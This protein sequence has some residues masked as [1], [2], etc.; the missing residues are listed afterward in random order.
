M[1]LVWAQGLARQRERVAGMDRMLRNLA[2]NEHPGEPD[3]VLARLRD[4]RERFA[5]ARQRL[6]EDAAVHLVTVPERLVIE[7]SVRARDVLIASGLRVDAVLVNRVLPPEADGE[8][9]AARRTQQESYLRDIATRLGD[10][11]QVLVPQ[12]RR[13]I[14]GREDLEAVI[15]ALDRAGATV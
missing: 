13:D 6:T 11:P 12:Q 1:V 3:P 14:A 5:R 15:G 4:R 10:H 2:G 7:E 9:L 8:F